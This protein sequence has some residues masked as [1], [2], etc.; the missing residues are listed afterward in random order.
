M[1]EKHKKSNEIL[2]RDTQK[3]YKYEPDVS[4]HSFFDNFNKRLEYQR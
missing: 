2:I 4:I 1:K 3:N